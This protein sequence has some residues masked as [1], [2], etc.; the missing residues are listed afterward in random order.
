MLRQIAM[1]KGE[2]STSTNRKFFAVRTRYEP[3]IEKILKLSG[4]TRMGAFVS[5]VFMPIE[6]QADPEVSR[7]GQ[8]TQV[9]DS[10][11]LGCFV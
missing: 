6:A 8:A 11:H 3:P 1:V 2:A 7:Y 4:S 9:R 5:K 10:S